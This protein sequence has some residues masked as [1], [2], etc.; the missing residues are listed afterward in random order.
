MR[1]EDTSAVHKAFEVLNKV[2]VEAKGRLQV[3]V[4]DHA[5]RDL[6]GDIPGIVGS[7]EWRNGTKLVPMKWLQGDADVATT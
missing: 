2:V 7:K 5:S 3:I 4:L 1:D 6:W